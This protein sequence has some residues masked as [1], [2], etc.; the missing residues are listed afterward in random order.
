M[1][2]KSKQIVKAI[3]DKKVKNKSAYAKLLADVD[4]ADTVAKLKAV[5]KDM[6]KELAE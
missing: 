5:V 6:L 1:N 2:D 3:A 4:K